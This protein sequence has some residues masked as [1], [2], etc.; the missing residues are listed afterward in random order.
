[1]SD[2]SH[3]MLSHGSHKMSLSG[4][5]LSVEAY[6]PWNRE[7]AEEYCDKVRE[8]TSDLIKEKK[9]WAVFIAVHGTGI[10]TPDSIDLL[11]EL[12]LWRLD[13]GMK[14]IAIL[15]SDSDSCGSDIL[16]KQLEPVY[17]LDEED[18][19]AHV[20]RYFKE[21]SDANKWLRKLGFDT[22]D[23]CCL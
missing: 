11:R 16:K 23:R 7:A 18:D 10:Y 1:M 19:E 12:H 6:G 2:L 14:H 22:K 21:R 8:L 15:C 3:S 20:E 5:L 17:C 13:N 4:N 9:E